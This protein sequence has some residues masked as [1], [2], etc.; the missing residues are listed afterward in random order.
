MVGLLLWVSTILIFIL[1][2]CAVKMGSTEVKEAFGIM[3]KYE[4]IMSSLSMTTIS[5]FSSVEGVLI[6]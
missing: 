2:K 5:V 6:D 4:E 1:E 3:H